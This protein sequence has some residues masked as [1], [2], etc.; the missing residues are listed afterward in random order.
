[1]NRL[2]DPAPPRAPPSPPPHPRTRQ[3]T[4]HPG[5]V[6]TA[7]TSK[8]TV[9]MIDITFL[10]INSFIECVWVACLVDGVGFLFSLQCHGPHKTI[11]K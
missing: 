3:H 2:A 5:R 4:H 6:C 1:M 8:H 11:A 10:V 7:L 9:K